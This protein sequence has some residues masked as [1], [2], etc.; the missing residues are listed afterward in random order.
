MTDE[1]ALRARNNMLESDNRLLE[2][3][4]KIL[5]NDLKVI[6]KERDDLKQDIADIEEHIEFKRCDSCKHLTPETIMSYVGNEEVCE[7]CRV[8]GYGR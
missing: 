5:K 7:N 3:Q 4:I 1:A 8:N 6:T 2:D